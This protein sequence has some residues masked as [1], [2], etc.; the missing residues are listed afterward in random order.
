MRHQTV[1]NILYKEH[2]IRIALRVAGRQ[3]H[4]PEM[5]HNIWYK[6]HLLGIAL[7][8]SEKQKHSPE[9]FQNSLENIFA[10]FSF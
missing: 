4:S 2:L 5:F 6:E 7:R 3:K 10:I 1:L 8:V 9:R